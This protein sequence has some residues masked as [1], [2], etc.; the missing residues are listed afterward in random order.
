MKRLISA[1]QFLTIL[2]IGKPGTFD[3]NMI[4]FFPVIGLILG[5]MLMIFDLAVSRLWTAP[6][7]AVLDVI[8][9]V[10]LTGALH[11]DGLGDTADGLYGNRPKE[12]ALVIMKDSRIG[13]MGLVAVVCGLAVK[14]G[15]VMSLDAHRS[16]LL[17]IIPAYARGGMLFG[18]RFL[19]YGRPDGGTGHAFFGETLKFSAFRAL[20]IPVFVSFFA[21]RRGLWLNVVFF[22][23]TVLILWFYKKRMG[24]ITGDMLGAMCEITES[25]LFLMVSIGGRL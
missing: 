25:M 17:F 14:W 8:F 15:G 23:T 3:K 22:I 9:L 20:L 6:V 16:L 10:I 13:A 1:I 24:C 21:G 7:A 19:E 12:K 11:L 18:F 5:M 2:P 4:V